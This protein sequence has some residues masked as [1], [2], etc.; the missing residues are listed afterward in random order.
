NLPQRPTMTEAGFLKQI[1]RQ[2]PRGRRRNLPRVLQLAARAVQTYPRSAR[3]LIALG[4][5]IEMSPDAK[6]NGLDPL[7]LYRKAIRHESDYWEGYEAAGFFYYVYAT[8]GS[9]KSLKKAEKM[10]RTA[11]RLGGGHDSFLGLAGTLL[12]KGKR[13]PARRALQKCTRRND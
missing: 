10:F 13:S 4:E 1:A 9:T 6:Y 2:W 11:I 8:Y 7:T 12:E 5:L 3:L